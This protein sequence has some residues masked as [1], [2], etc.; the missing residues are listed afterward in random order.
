LLPPAHGGPVR[1]L[2]RRY[3]DVRLL[4]QPLAADPAMLTEGLA[5]SA[6]IERQLWQHAKAA[7]GEAPTPIVATFI[8][9]L[10]EMID[11]DAERT[12]ASRNRIPSAVW[13]LLLIVASLAEL[14]SGYAGGAQGARTTLNTV[15]LPLLL[16]VVM[17]LIYDMANPR[18]GLIG[19][20]QQSL[21][22]LQQF[23]RESGSP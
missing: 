14:T 6:D 22:D 23:V 10:N 8:T 3:V 13:L 16:A 4:Y 9:T 19:I 11:V 12:A 20:N 2:L 15:V 18:R 1:R 21:I 7:A 5:L 17:T